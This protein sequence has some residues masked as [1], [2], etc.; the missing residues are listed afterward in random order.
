MQILFYIF[1]LCAIASSAQEMH[2]FDM[3][4]SHGA[5]LKIVEVV[6]HAVWC[7]AETGIMIAVFIMTKKRISHIESRYNSLWIALLVLCGVAGIFDIIDYGKEESFITLSGTLIVLAMIVVMAVLGYKIAR[8]YDGKIRTIG[9]VFT[10]APGICLITGL[11]IMAM[12]PDSFGEMDTRTYDYGGAYIRYEQSYNTSTIVLTVVMA[13]VSALMEIIPVGACTEYI[14]TTGESDDDLSSEG[15]S[16]NIS[17]TETTPDLAVEPEPVAIQSPG[18]SDEKVC[19]FDDATEEEPSKSRKKKF[20]IVISVVL[21]VIVGAAVWAY[22]KSDD[23]VGD[24][25]LAAEAIYE[26]GRKIIFTSDH[27]VKF[28]D[29]GENEEDVCASPEGSWWMDGGVLVCFTGESTYHFSIIDGYEYQGEYRSEDGM[30]YNEEWVGDQETGGLDDV[31]Y[32]PTPSK[33]T[34]LKSFKWVKSQSKS[35]DSTEDISS[36]YDTSDDLGKETWMEIVHSVGLS[37]ITLGTQAGNRYDAENL[38]DGD[39]KTAW[40]IGGKEFNE[41][42]IETE[43]HFPRMIYLRPKDRCRIIAIKLLNGYQKSISSWE[44]NAR[45]RTITIMG[46]SDDSKFAQVLFSGNVADSR[47]WQ[48]VRFTKT[49]IYD[50]YSFI[51]E[52]IYHGIKYDDVGISEMKFFSE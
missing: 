23:S 18:N 21:V 11:L 6:P 52:D 43:G 28:M 31:G 34:K 22:T 45:A 41:Y 20:A 25:N 10:F 42:E 32:Y 47:D 2:L 17:E 38:F 44:N 39:D 51:I 27:K 12:L 13:L 19:N 40:V 14:R 48:Y 37:K 35:K 16:D 36:C 46:C 50:Y 7:V 33:G 3:I 30:C 15:E 4:E 5:L 1:I 9:N 26:N 8:N 49:G 24:N 29:E